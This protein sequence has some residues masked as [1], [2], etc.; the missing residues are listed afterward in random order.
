MSSKANGFIFTCP[1]LGF[2]LK[3]RCES[4]TPDEFNRPRTRFS[5]SRRDHD[6]ARHH[7][8]IDFRFSFWRSLRSARR[9][10]TAVGLIALVYFYVEERLLKLFDSVELEGSDPWGL[11]RIVRDEARRLS[12]LVPRVHLLKIQTPT[13]LSVG[14]FRKNA[15]LFV[16]EGLL[17]RLSREELI[18]VIA[19]EME[20]LR[21]DQSQSTTA[22]VSVASLIATVANAFDAVLTY[23]IQRRRLELRKRGPMTLLL[24]P[25]VLLITRMGVRKKQLIEA[26][27]KTAQLASLISTNT[28]P[29]K[30]DELWARTLA[31]LDAYNKTLPLDVNIAEAALFV[32]NPLARFIGHASLSPFRAAGPTIEERL[33]KLTGRFPL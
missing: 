32:V 17:R 16:T 20:R 10:F 6:G 24:A 21:T 2:Q 3:S 19:F 23:P 27:Q 25:V 13:A 28:D 15:K 1:R 11:L 9:I 4:Q 18:L 12:I 22:V 7:L 33:M 14:L 31:K 29:L 8:F 5:I 30:T 26:D